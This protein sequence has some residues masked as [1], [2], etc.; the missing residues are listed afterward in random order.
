MA[1]DPR[2]PVII[3]VG[4]HLN[5]VDRGEDPAEPVELMERAVRAAAADAGAPDAAAGADVL[6]VVP[7]VSW[8][9]RDPGALLAGRLGATGAATWYPS[10]GG[11]TPQLLVNRLARAIAAGEADLGVVTGGEAYRSRMAARKAGTELDWT[12]QPDDVEPTWHEGTEFTLG[13]PAELARGIMM[14]T[15]AYPL[16]ENALWHTSGRGRDEHLAAVGELWA[17]FSR[18]AAANPHAWRRDAYTA[19]EITTPTAENRLVGSPYTKRMVS[20]PDVD[21]SSALLLCSVE[22][23]RA[24]GVSADR[25]VFPHAGTDAKD[26]VMSQRP[27]FTSSASIGV[28]GNRALELAGVGIDDVAHVD[29][30]SCFPSAVQLALRE[31]GVAWDRQ[32]TVWGGLCFAGGPWNNPVGHALA[33]MVGVLRED[34]G[35]TGLVTANGGNVEKHAFGVYSTEPP[36]DGFRWERPQAEV[37]ARGHREVDGEGSGPVTVEAWTVMHER[38]GSPAR[39]HAACLTPDG[40]RVW[41]VSDD[42]DLMARAAVED[43]GGVAGAVDADGTLTLDG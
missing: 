31:L 28:A 32:V 42:P 13:H 4:Q 9:Y 16:F 7:V 39:A 19:A 1:L 18:V 27:S 2:T 10:M 35:S 15:Q 5:R 38:D 12:R 22:R 25:W 17:G 43:L 11:N 8:R 40:V 26:G 29:L 36:A 20:N 24:L 21:M 30:Y 37:D 23:A 14:P 34:P 6:G 33:S 3:G 41:G